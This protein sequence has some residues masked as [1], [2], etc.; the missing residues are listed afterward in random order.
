MLIVIVETG[1]STHT[2]CEV[3]SIVSPSDVVSL[4]DIVVGLTDVSTPM[5]VAG[6][7]VMVVAGGVVMGV[8]RVLVGKGS[9]LNNNQILLNCSNTNWYTY[10]SIEVENS[11]CLFP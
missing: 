3:G 1:A 7:M 6:G 4:V 10:I 11:G 2:C 5:V 9:V 8:A